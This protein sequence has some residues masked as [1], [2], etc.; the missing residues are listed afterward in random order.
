MP[1]LIDKPLYYSGISPFFSC[2]RTVGHTGLLVLAVLVAARLRRSSTLAALGIGML[3]H[4]LLDNALALFSTGD[5]SAWMAMTWPL[6]PFVHQ[7]PTSLGRHLRDLWNPPI[8]VSEIVGLALFT[9]EARRRLG[10]AR[11]GTPPGPRRSD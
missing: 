6:N 8:V 11:A 3:T 5:H 1:D 9:W 4:L 7:F 10:H 2:T